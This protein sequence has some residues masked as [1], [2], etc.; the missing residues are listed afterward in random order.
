MQKKKIISSLFIL[1]LFSGASY[2]L[3][4]VEWPINQITIT[5]DY[6]QVIPSQRITPVWNTLNIWDVSMINGSN[7]WFNASN[8]WKKYPFVD[9][10]IIMTATGGRSQLTNEYYSEDVNGNPIYNFQQL[11]LALNW[12]I[13]ANLTATI[14]IGNVPSKMT[15]G[16]INYGAFD[17]NIGMPMN[18]TKYYDYIANLTL[19]VLNHVSGNLSRFDWRVMTEPDNRDWIATPELD[20]YFKIWTASFRAIRSVLPNAS[21][22]LGNMCR[23]KPEDSLIPF[24]TRLKAEASDTIPTSVGYSC[25]GGGQVGRDYREIGIS[26]KNWH[27]ALEELNLSNLTVKIEEGQILSDDAGYLWNGDGTEFGAAWNAGVFHECLQN[28]ISRYTQWDFYSGEVRS[29]SLNVIEMFEKIEGE[30]LVQ[31]TVEYPFYAK[32]SQIK[33]NAIATINSITN[34]GHLMIYFADQD[35]F[36][37]TKYPIKLTIRNAPTAMNFTSPTLY[38]VDHTHSNYF[39]D[40]EAAFPN[41]PQGNVSG[42]MNSRWDM[43]GATRYSGTTNLNGYYIWSWEHRNDYQL[44]NVTSPVFQTDVNGYLLNMDIHANSVRLWE[45]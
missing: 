38:L 30:K 23:E 25:Y 6:A 3:W 11:L 32:Y 45:F 27:E 33:L 1:C 20:N 9:H 22:E 16:T 29:P 41:T 10:L 15:N 4:V 28:N 31:C 37:T 34:K 12:I 5:I 17:A 13:Q 19:A 14:V 44:E 8:Y 43:N 26:G 7:E 21:I 18:L 35:H 24:L 42:R 39:W 2:G 36:A 40:L